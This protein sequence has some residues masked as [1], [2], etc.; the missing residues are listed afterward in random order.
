MIGLIMFLIHVI[1]YWIMVLLYDGKVPKNDFKMAA[2]SSFKNQILYTLPSTMVFFNYYPINYEH[3]FSSFGYLPILIITSDCYFYISH[4]PLHT[5][6]LYHLHKHHH[7]GTVCVA[8]SLDA[9]GLE[10]LFGNLGSFFVGIVLLW[11]F[12]FIIN[13]YII[14]SWV[15]FATINT[16]ISH[17][18]FQCY[19]DTGSHFNHH[20]YRQCNYGFG[21]YLLDHLS[22]TYK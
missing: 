22:G 4:R 7:T 16:C 15:G 8:K 19:L 3:F 2:S 18:N 1:C 11:Y 5:Q 20:K 12:G 13:I 21:L 14:G 17:S 9:N 10:H 6:W